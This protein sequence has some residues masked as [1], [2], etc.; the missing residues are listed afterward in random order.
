MGQELGWRVSSP[1]DITFSPLEQVEVDGIAEAQ[2]IGKVTNL[3]ELWLRRKSQI[4]TAK[5]NWL[6][7]YQFKGG[8]GWESMFLPNGVGTV[9][10]RL[11]WSVDIPQGYFLLVLP[12]ETTMEGVEILTG[13]LSSSATDRMSENGVSLAMKPTT[14]VTIRRKQ[15]IARIVLLHADSL[16]AR[17]THSG[18]GEWPTSDGRSGISEGE[19]TPVNVLE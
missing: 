5:S 14:T 15:P 11:G 4:A 19:S 6:H 9:E 12:G 17:S 2:E 16:R 10:W 18:Y 13:V 8:Q 3:S 7:L 1:V